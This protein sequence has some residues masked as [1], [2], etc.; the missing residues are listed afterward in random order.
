ML[1]SGGFA[2]SPL[3]Y[4]LQADYLTGIIALVE[5]FNLIEFFGVAALFGWLTFARLTDDENKKR[6]V[7][8]RQNDSKCW[9]IVDDQQ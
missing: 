8:M 7:K 6:V 5:L 3:T 2:S 4:G 9:L 1:T